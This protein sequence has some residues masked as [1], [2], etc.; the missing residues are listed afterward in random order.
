MQI[1]LK[2]LFEVEIRHDYFL[3]P[4]ATT[5]YTSDYDIR[6]IFLIEPSEETITVLHDYKMIFKTTA[7]GFIVFVQAE[8]IPTA[9]VYVSLIDFSVDLKFSFYW[10]LLDPLFENY[11][12][13]RVKEKEKRIY[14]FSNR[15]GTQSVGISYLNNAIVPFGTTYNG[16]PLYRL[17]DI[18]SESAETYEM[19]DKEAPVINF[20]ANSTKWQKINTS[21]INYVNPDSRATLQSSRFT[22][23]RPNSS[24]G[25]FMVANL[26]DV[27]NQPVPLGFIQGTNSPQNEYRSSFNSNDPVNFIMDFGGLSPG[28]YKLEIN[29]SIGITQR[30]FYLMDALKMPEL[31][32]VSE[33]FVSGATAAFEFIKEY[34]VLHRWV[35]DN[36]NKKFMIRFRNRLTRWR[37][38]NQDQT[39]FNEPLLPRPLTKEYSAYSVPGPGGTTIN[40]PDPSIA[41][42]APEFETST[43]LVKNIYSKIFLTK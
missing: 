17:G 13:K 40:L 39:V 5:K 18:V 24:P 26:F 41:S 28:R 23:Q 34:P 21:V 4:V 1:V 11:T 2:K 29:E 20:L 42:I 22:Y 27:N 16:E 8:F 37:Y 19:I 32:G 3:L 7:T 14:Y 12:N 35:L 36:P 9:N 25:E 33:F 31:Y 10:T 30:S 15:I 6:K 43:Q 38:L